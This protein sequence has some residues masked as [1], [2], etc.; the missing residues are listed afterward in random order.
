MAS[1]PKK[2]L[3]RVT[4]TV[5]MCADRTDIAYVM[6]TKEHLAHK[7]AIEKLLSSGYFHVHPICCEVVTNESKDM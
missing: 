6:A 5:N 2:R 3:W 7:K 4:C 1:G